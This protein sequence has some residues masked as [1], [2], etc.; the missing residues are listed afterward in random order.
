MARWIRWVL[1]AAAVTAVG[2][3]LVLAWVWRDRPDLEALGVPVSS[4]ADQEVGAAGDEVSVTWLGVT[5]LRFDDG[6]TTLLTDG[7][8]SRP[9]VVDLVLDRPVAPDAAGIE[10]AIRT[11]GIGEVAALMT[12]HSHFDHA[13]D[14]GEVAK[15]TGAFVLGSSSTAN[16]ARGAGLPEARIVAVEDGHREGFGRFTV[17]F[18]ASRHV[19]APGGGP[20]FPGA[21]EEPLTPPAPPSAWREGGSWSILIEHP[22]GAA[23]VQGSAGFV[24]GALEGVRADVVFLSVGFL[25]RQG[26]DY[27]ARYWDEIVRATGARRVILVHF[28][29]FTRPWGE[30]RPLPR[31]L[32][33]VETSF[34]WLAAHASEAQPPVRL[35][36]PPFGRPVRLFGAPAAPGS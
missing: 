29:D 28:D 27:A 23:L 35:E 7:F 30:V 10:R 26:A 12:V 5:T 22:R 6:E 1:M 31:L 4:A 17:T 36:R 8:F 14:T 13:M 16:A 32:D 19:P 15:R 18:L 33:D 25:A 9:G 21:I 34:G 20:P 2:I 3:A 24:P 11:A